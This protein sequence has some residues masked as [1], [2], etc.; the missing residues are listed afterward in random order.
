MTSIATAADA[1]LRK[2]IV[3]AALPLRAWPVAQIGAV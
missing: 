1:D 2:D 3:R